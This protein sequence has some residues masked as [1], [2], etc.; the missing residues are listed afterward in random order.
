MSM[1][2][3]FLTPIPVCWR[4]VTI[5]KANKVLCVLHCCASFGNEASQE[6]EWTKSG[7]TAVGD[8]IQYAN[9]QG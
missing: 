3:P 6:W 9:C 2:R 5:M 4:A 1:P 8:V 7:L